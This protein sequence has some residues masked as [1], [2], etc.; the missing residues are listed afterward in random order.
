MNAKNQWKENYRATI[1]IA[2][3]CILLGLGV[4]SFFDGKWFT[5]WGSAFVGLG[6]VAFFFAYTIKKKYLNNPSI[7]TKGE[8]Q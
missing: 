5:F 1:K 4:I 3:M 8:P 6:C 7:A 2:L